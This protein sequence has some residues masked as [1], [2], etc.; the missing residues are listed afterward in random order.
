MCTFWK[1]ISVIADFVTIIGFPVVVYSF[2]ELYYS[3]TIVYDSYREV[4]EAGGYTIVIGN[5][6]QRRGAF[7]RKDYKKGKKVNPNRQYHKMGFDFDDEEAW[8]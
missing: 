5:K 4:N 6:D 8:I 2:Y 7:S 3:K 1:A